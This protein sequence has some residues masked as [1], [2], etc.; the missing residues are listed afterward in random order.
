MIGMFINPS[1]VR[2]KSWLLV[3]QDKHILHPVPPL[4][5]LSAEQGR[6]PALQLGTNVHRNKKKTCVCQSGLRT[7]SKSLAP[8]KTSAQVLQLLFSLGAIWA[9][10]E[11]KFKG[12]S[13]KDL[14]SQSAKRAELGPVF[15]PTDPGFHLSFQNSALI[16]RILYFSIFLDCKT[17]CRGY[18]GTWLLWS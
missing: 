4:F 6:A 14:A 18:C 12:T 16:Q 5:I 1:V 3:H 10:S 8:G 15:L 17:Y 7:C 13:Q 9:C 2:S 11:N